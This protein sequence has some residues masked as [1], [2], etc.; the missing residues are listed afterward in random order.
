MSLDKDPTDLLANLNAQSGVRR[1]G[2]HPCAQGQTHHG[3]SHDENL[4]RFVEI[5]NRTRHGIVAKPQPVNQA[6]T[7]K[8]PQPRADATG[9][10]AA[11]L[12]Q[13]WLEHGPVWS[14]KRSLSAVQL[15]AGGRSRPILR[16]AI[17]T[18]QPVDISGGF[19]IS[20]VKT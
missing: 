9:F 3:L 17:T 19:M 1:L 16:R 13:F 5:M 4:Y 7:S 14:T 10:F 8:L 18:E 2:G 6:A 11:A 12:T 20:M 15:S